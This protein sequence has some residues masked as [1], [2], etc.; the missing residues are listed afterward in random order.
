MRTAV[1]IFLL[2]CCYLLGGTDAASASLRASK[3]YFVSE[4]ISHDAHLQRA[5]ALHDND[6]IIANP[7]TGEEGNQFIGIDVDDEDETEVFVRKN[8]QL[9]K[10]ISAFLYA[11]RSNRHYCPSPTPPSFFNVYF[12]PCSGLYIQLRT[13]RI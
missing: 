1:V 6:A 12:Y 5:I 8:F 7:R 9:D 4:K 10:Q 13:L 2:L 3:T 11:L